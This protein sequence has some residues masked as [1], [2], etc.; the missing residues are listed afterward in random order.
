LHVAPVLCFVSQVAPQAPQFVVVSVLVSQPSR[1]G[2]A[3]LQS[4]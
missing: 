4:A 2:A 1:S 3:L